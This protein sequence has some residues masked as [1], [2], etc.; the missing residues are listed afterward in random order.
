M[1]LA[2]GACDDASAPNARRVGVL[3][4]PDGRVMAWYPKVDARAFPSQALQQL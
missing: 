3:I 4:G 1:G 2:Y